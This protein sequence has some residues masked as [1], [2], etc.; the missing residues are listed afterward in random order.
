M[1]LEEQVTYLKKGFSELLEED[2]VKDLPSY[3]LLKSVYSEYL[4]SKPERSKTTAQKEDEIFNPLYAPPGVRRRN[5][6]QAKKQLANTSFGIAPPQARAQTP[7]SKTAPTST[8]SYM[9]DFGSSL[10][11]GMDKPRKSDHGRLQ[12]QIRRIH[13]LLLL[14]KL[15]L[16]SLFTL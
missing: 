11:E 12:P 10:L 14:S 1:A 5:N 13:L 9:P 4:D 16:E 15:K 2:D 7:A 8:P 3:N 6:A